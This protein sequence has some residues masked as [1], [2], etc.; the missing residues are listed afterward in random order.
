VADFGV[1]GSATLFGVGGD[2]VDAS[3][4]GTFL[5][6]G[7]VVV[8]VVVVAVFLGVGVFAGEALSTFIVGFA[9]LFVGVS[10]LVPLTLSFEDSTGVAGV[11]A[12]TGGSFSSSTLTTGASTGFADT[13]TSIGFSTCFSFVL[14]T[15]SFSTLTIAGD[16]IDSLV[17]TFSGGDKFIGVGPTAIKLLRTRV[18]GVIPFVPRLSVF[19]PRVGVPPL[20][21][22]SKKARNEETCM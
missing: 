8:V 14:S 17:S 11:S 1:V 21:W 13:G 5:E 3:G 2:L 9:A 16:P 4:V 18:L 10:W 6:S 19:S 15:F 22:F 12:I 20:P 7:G